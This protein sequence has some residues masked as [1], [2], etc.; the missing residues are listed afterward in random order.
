[1][2]RRLPFLR[3]PLWGVALLGAGCATVP[4]DSA[5]REFSQSR[6]EQADRSLADLP[7]DRNRILHL[8]ERGMI[9][10]LRRD[11]TGST[12]DWMEAVRLE[13]ALET[14]SVS[15]AGA[16]MVVNDT[17]LD[18]RGYPYERMLLHAYLAR[19]YLAQGLWEEAAVEGRR[20]AR[21]L[22][23]PDGFP[24]VA[25]CR[26]LAAFCFELIG[27]SSSAAMQYRVTAA[28][29]PAARLE[30]ETGRFRLGD[31]THAAPAAAPFLGTELVCFVDFD[32]AY[33]L[34][35]EY[36]E[37]SA[38]GRV[39]GVSRTLDDIARLEL[40]SA[41]R[42][43]ARRGL[44]T[45]SRLALKYTVATAA[46]QRNHDL[47]Q[48]LWLLLLAAEQPD[49]RRWETLPARLAVVRA[50][51]PENLSEFDVTFRSASGTPL[52]KI[53]VKQPIVRNG[54]VFVSFCRDHPRPE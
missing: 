33:G 16:S 43:A 52:R 27:D 2:R 34:V 14:H 15:K 8:M 47:G 5:R 13:D 42:M 35:P 23:N 19:N 22:E 41:Q 45:A 18:F 7:S 32:G 20:M 39:I 9:R 31:A 21:M 3:H 54:R 53:V 38:G 1:M 11:Y 30:P 37:V 40:A 46:G 28:R 6:L 49:E 10:H 26:Y 17:L 48:L 24:E 50:P 25:Y 29:T 44:K 4:L 12:L 51:C 36:A